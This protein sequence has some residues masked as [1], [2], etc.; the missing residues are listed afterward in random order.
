MVQT[1]VFFHWRSRPRKP[2]LQT[3]KEKVTS[4][5]RMTF[6]AGDRDR[7]VEAVLPWKSTGAPFPPAN[8]SLSTPRKGPSG[9][10]TGGPR[11][12]AHPTV[13][14]RSSLPSPHVTR[15]RRHLLPRPGR[16]G[17]WATAVVLGGGGGDLQ[18]HRDPQCSL[19]D[20]RG[21]QGWEGL[22]PFGDRQPHGGNDATTLRGA[23][24]RNGQ[25]PG[26]PSERLGSLLEPGGWLP[27][28]VGPHLSVSP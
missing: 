8:K 24:P 4:G 5:S 17:P 10:I 1:T 3:R 9:E 22:F 15:P 25:S 19:G 6:G 26:A 23:E 21:P 18:T 27:E 2:G 16:K 11:A 14:L 20:L 13:P 28:Q 7:S 12:T